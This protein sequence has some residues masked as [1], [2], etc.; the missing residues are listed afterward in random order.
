MRAGAVPRVMVA[1][2]V[3]FATTTGVTAAKA[4]GNDRPPGAPTLLTVDDAAAPLA[5]EGAPQF[6]WVVNDPDRGEV[7]TAY[8]L[9]VSE[10]PTR[11]GSAKEI[12]RSGEVKSS[13]QSYVQA[14]GLHLESD[15][16]Y[17]WVVRT[18][19][20]AGR[21]GPYSHAAHFDVGLAD[22]DWNAD[23]IRRP[24]VSAG[25]VEDFTL[26][27]KEF[28]VG[29]SPVVRARAYSSA[30]QQ[31]DLRVN[32]VRVAHGPSYAYPDEQYYETTDITG[33]IEPGRVNAVGALTH[34]EYPGQGRPASV[35]GLI[36][37]ITIEHAD[38]SREVVTTDG[39]W[40]VHAGPFVPDKFRNSE[41]NLVE[42]E[43]GRLDLVGWDRAGFDDRSWP[44]AE[45]L[46]AH[47]VAPF[48][49]LYAERSHI[50]EQ[51]V[52]PV[53]FERT[54]N[55]SYVADY[56]AVVAATPVV[57]FHAGVSG[58]AVRIVGGY[59][60]DPN[61]HVSTTR[62]VQQTD[63]HWDYTERNGAQ[64]FRPF[65]Y[66]G[67]RYLEVIGAGEALARGDVTAYARHASFP[68]EH[69]A[70]FGSS[71]PTLNAI[72]DLARHSAMY[73]SQEQFLD[74]PT[75]EQGAFQDPN[76]SAAT[77]AA[78]D[79]RAMTFQALRDVARSQ[80]RFWPDGRVNPVYPNGDGKRDIPDS[81]EQYV[82]WVWQTYLATGDTSQLASLY[83]VVKN[84]S[85]YVERAVDP[86][87]GLVTRLPGGGSDY[88]Y[89]LV[90]WPP[91]MRYGYDM[92]TAAR[93]T[94]NALAVDV[95][96][97]V[98]EMGVALHRPSIETDA[99]AARA[100]ALQTAMRAR[101][102]RPDGVFVDGLES[103]DAQ[104]KHASQ[105]AN[106]LALDFG[107]V[108]PAQVAAVADHVVRFGNAVGVSTF[109][110]LLTALHVAD[111]DQALLAALTDP[112]RPG[113]AQIIREGATYGWES[114]DARQTGD[115][116]SHAFGSNVLVN[117]QTDV[118]GVSVTEPGAGRIDVQVPNLTPMRVA[119]VVATQRGR[120]LVSWQRP[121]P[122]H[123]TMDVA[124]PDNVVA[125]L[126][127]P[128]TSVAAV[129]DGRLPLA[130]D[131]G[132]VSA[133]KGPGGVVVTVGSGRYQLRIPAHSLRRRGWGLVGLLGIVFVV[134][135]LIGGL[136]F[137]RESR[138]PRRP[139]GRA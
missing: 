46:G 19:D 65:D 68:D 42:H 45:V 128:A 40:R 76:T 22:R 53:T 13:Q 101:L 123:F 61:G 125:T 87:T 41:G 67:F 133:A 84:I 115:S 49:H 47:P 106:A 131:P 86:G 39:S 34:L 111:R 10:E 88:L 118:L 62:G 38:G 4:S 1:A 104:S 127:L 107:I 9:V 33:Q 63:M 129:S 32:G 30:G 55:G 73:A 51:P 24:G 56:G 78:F 7:Q 136:A 139:A 25:A 124:V 97:R 120:V 3:V 138:Q 71:D 99:E 96:R 52:A 126:H 112:N 58:R 102:R 110:S 59:L 116:E 60:L 95:F 113:F 20:R 29:A 108:P 36:V 137:I 105:L 72:W 119:G 74:T 17:E 8:E 12:W 23:W 15:H 82:E 132:V 103:N 50:V 90:D 64:E 83:P 26:A 69:A 89:G 134:I 94:E 14:P 85:D 81:T 28:R 114:W 6:G 75:R 117:L 2:L 109:G 92:A 79:D 100:N 77:M 5:V 70:T 11:A 135:A 37:R 35:P 66:L 121:E 91:Q 44:K 18:W 93:T 31:L 48:L 43:D 27:R 80:R 130:G 21:A 16:A 57:D 122:A 54:S 98:A